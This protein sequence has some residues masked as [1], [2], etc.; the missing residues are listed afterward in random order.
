MSLH[1]WLLPF[2]SDKLWLL[3]SHCCYC[4]LDCP[5]SKQKQTPVQIF[6]E[7]DK[8]HCLIFS[9]GAHLSV[10]G[11][12][13]KTAYMW[14]SGWK[15]LQTSPHQA[16][17]PRIAGGIF[18]SVLDGANVSWNT[19]S[20]EAQ[21]NGSNSVEGEN[22]LLLIMIKSLLRSNLGQ[23]LW[24]GGQKLKKWRHTKFVWPAR[25]VGA[26]TLS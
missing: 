21:A 10:F 11:N 25:V 24:S 15:R 17:F 8:S 12:V 14:E 7:A 5:A 18:S 4:V 20:E 6:D 23:E 16:G 9:G 26:F 1:F 19:I 3:S 22:G 13:L 2:V